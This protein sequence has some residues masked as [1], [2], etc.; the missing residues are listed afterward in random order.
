MRIAMML[1][2]ASLVVLATAVV[3]P[4]PPLAPWAKAAVSS[5]PFYPQ[6]VFYGRSW[7]AANIGTEGD[8]APRPAPRA[9][10]DFPPD[11]TKNHALVV[12]RVL[13]IRDPAIVDHLD[14]QSD[15][16]AQHADSQPGPWSFARLMARAFQ[17]K[18]PLAEEQSFDEKVRKWVKAWS[19]SGGPPALS[20]LGSKNLW[21]AA[22]DPPLSK[23]PVRLLAVVNRLDLARMGVD[24]NGHDLSEGQICHPEVRF[25][26]AA[27]PGVGNK[28]F[29]ELILEFVL[30]CYSKENFLKYAAGWDLLRN[31][32]PDTPAYLA[33]LEGVLESSLSSAT[34]VRLRLNVTTGRVWDFRQY[35]FSDQGLAEAVLDEQPSKLV[36]LLVCAA[37][38]PLGDYIRTNLKSIVDSR[39]NY[40]PSASFKCS[41]TNTELATCQAQLTQASQ[42][43]LTLSPEL[44]SPDVTKD[45]AELDAIRFSLSISSCVGCHGWETTKLPQG[46]TDD[47]PPSTFDHVKYREKDAAS[48]LSRFLAGDGGTF[49]VPTPVNAPWQ[50][51][52]PQASCD[53]GQVNGSIAPLRKYNDL[54]RRH[55]YLWTVLNVPSDKWETELS[56]FASPQA[57]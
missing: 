6:P 40:V 12:D 45:P 44:L 11:E 49:E 52:A 1:A 22:S 14:F 20:D 9:A 5:G 3:W 46:N 18:V 43:S 51:N 19:L 23:M 30:P 26:F 17:L 27:I 24:S 47:L 4:G 50:V 41:A 54:L 55:Q 34:D 39:P 13:L 48:G 37:A 8:G 42:V 10:T 2:S 21:N 35:S 15:P 36:N 53:S 57:H 28:P 31:N 25:V 56:A 38:Y 7:Q 32:A 33:A 29:L 16:S